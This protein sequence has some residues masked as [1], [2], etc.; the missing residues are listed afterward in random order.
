MKQIET[1]LISMFSWRNTSNEYPQ[2][3]GRDVPRC[4]CFAWNA[5]LSLL[6]CKFVARIWQYCRARCFTLFQA[7]RDTFLISMQYFRVWHSMSRPTSKP[8]K[9]LCHGKKTWHVFANIKIMYYLCDRRPY[10]RIP[11]SGYAGGIQAWWKAFTL[12]YFLTNG[13][14]VNFNLSQDYGKQ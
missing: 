13:N 3:Q 8:E 11:V 7:H 5:S 4:G 1:T 12:R 9:S 6:R 2:Q 14:L 10:R